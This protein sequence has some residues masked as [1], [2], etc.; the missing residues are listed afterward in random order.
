MVLGPK[1]PDKVAKAVAEAIGTD[2]LV[3]DINDIDGVILGAS[4]KDIDR[5]LCRR[6][7]SD[8]PLG[9]DCQQTPMGIIR[10]QLGE[11]KA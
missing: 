4:R 5:D 6:I 2:C 3:V 9:Q 10:K 7:L 11:N 1:D 8:N